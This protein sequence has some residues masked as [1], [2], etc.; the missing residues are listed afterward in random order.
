MEEFTS[1][2]KRERGID[3][4]IGAASTVMRMLNWSGVVK[5]EE[6]IK[7]GPM[8]DACSPQDY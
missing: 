3:R 4:R 8:R 7:T 5:M 6:P 2:G 1:E